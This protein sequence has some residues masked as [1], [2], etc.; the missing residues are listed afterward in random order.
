MI[1]II[2][3]HLSVFFQIWQSLL[4]ITQYLHALLVGLIQVLVLLHSHIEVSQSCIQIGSRHGIV[5][6]NDLVAYL[7]AILVLAE[8]EQ[9]GTLG[10]EINIVQR[11]NSQ[12]LI[13]H[14]HR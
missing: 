10:E 12:R 13:D 1:L 11:I 7:D 14:I 8:I 2:G 4:V 3:H 6:G 5:L 9:Q